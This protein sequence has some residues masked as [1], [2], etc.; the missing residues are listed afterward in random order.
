MR[1]ELIYV[2]L[3]ETDLACINIVIIVTVIVSLL[4]MRILLREF[5]KYTLDLLAGTSL[6]SCLSNKQRN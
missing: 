3:L 6:Q 2:K 5:E 1:T 4:K